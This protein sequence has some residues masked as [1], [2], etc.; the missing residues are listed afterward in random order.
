MRY[1]SSC[2]EGLGLLKNSFVPF[3]DLVLAADSP[4][5]LVF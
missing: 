1:S 3:S 5:F 2:L 4:V